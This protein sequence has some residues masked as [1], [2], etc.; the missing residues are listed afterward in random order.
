MKI[1]QSKFGK[2][3]NIFLKEPSSWENKIFITIDLDWCSDIVLSYT[4]DILEKSNIPVTFF[5]THE[6]NLLERI[7]DN[8]NFELGI[9]P[10]FNPLL[11]GNFKYGENVEEVLDFYKK[12]VPEAQSVRSHSMTQNTPIIDAFEKFDLIYDCN[13]FI[14]YSSGIKLKPYKHWTKN[15]LKIPYFWEDDIHCMYDWM[16]DVKE[17]VSADS[18]KVFDFHPIHIFL[19]TEKLDRY[20][21]SKN[22]LYKSEDK[23]HKLRYDGYGIN[24]FLK[25]LLE[26]SYS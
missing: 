13:T 10:N 25:D 24:N 22:L 23:V 2:I 26:H 5:V 14:P 8:P 1:K 20:E 17:F 4:L 12:I 7:R 21:K 16:W 15:I 9:H 18:L 6:T 3:N 19:N 11:N